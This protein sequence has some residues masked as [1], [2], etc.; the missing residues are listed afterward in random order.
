M[1][2]T[3]PAA[4]SGPSRPRTAST[5][6][7][8]C[9]GSSGG[10]MW[11]VDLA[12]RTDGARA[13]PRSGRPWPGT[14]PTPSSSRPGSRSLTIDQLCALF[15]A[16]NVT[17]AFTEPYRKPEP[18]LYDAR[19]S[20]QTALQ[21]GRRGVEAAAGAR[22]ATQIGCP[23]PPGPRWTPGERRGPRD[24]AQAWP[25]P[26]P[27]PPTST[28]DLTV[29]NLSFLYRHALLA[30]GAPD[31]GPGV[32]DAPLPRR[33]RPTC[34]PTRRRRWSSSQVVDRMKAAKLSVDAVELRA[35]GGCLPPREPRP[36]RCGHGA[37]GHS[38]TTLEAIAGRE[39][40]RLPRPTAAD[41]LATATSSPSCRPWAGI[42][43]RPAPSSIS[44]AT[45]FRA[46]GGRCQP[47]ASFTFLGRRAW[48][49]T[50][51]RYEIGDQ[52]RGLHRLHDA[53]PRR[54]RSSPSPQRRL[55]GGDR[56]HSR[57][58]NAS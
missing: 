24:P 23:R 22:G 39:R 45:T 40:Q 37:G 7:S 41:A 10:R 4:G 53:T 21:S 31:E 50:P 15:G 11:E 35:R 54:R 49:R 46:C 14:W 19:P 48:R 58:A 25:T 26:S 20:S 30:R 43:P 13:R 2:P 47:A 17:P 34:S 44:W 28:G 33:N 42:P 55:S 12:I 16:I 51:S 3:K 18:S 29:E 8:A 6:S 9:G 36:R 56:G 32:E 57:D 1:S 5:G 38:E 52:Q 27:T